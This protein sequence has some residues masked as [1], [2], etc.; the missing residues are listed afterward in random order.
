MMLKDFIIK[1]AEG[2]RELQNKDGSFP[3][4][5]NGPY[6]DPETPVRN[7]GHWLVIFAKCYKLTGDDKFKTKVYEV[8]EYLC[9]KDARPNGY[10]FY[11]RNKKNKD[12][13]NGLIGQAW[14]FEALAEAT[15]LLNAGKYALLAEEVFLRHPFNEEYGL[16]NRL[17]V[18]GRVLTIDGTFNHQLWFAA[19]SSLI[20]CPRNPE[21]MSRVKRF[22]DCLPRN[23]TILKNGLVYHHIERSLEEQITHN[24]TQ[25]DKVKRCLGGIIRALKSIKWIERILLR[26]RIKGEIYRSVGYHSF[27]L[28]AFAILKSQF[29]K[30]PFWNSISLRKAVAYM[31]TDEYR[32]KIDNNKYG[33]SY[34]PP[35]FEIPYSLYILGDINKKKLTEISQWWINEQ[36]RRCYNEKTGMMDRNTEDALTHT[37]RIYELC[38]LPIDVFREITIWEY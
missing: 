24:F 35:G 30:H 26:I 16:W 12:R 36:F 27:N 15:R 33:Y 38:R 7:S 6:F 22:M 34:N 14:T 11:H 3:A 37:A 19:S 18:D 10:S 20:E 13:C 9:S 1:T 28:Y 31:L 32:D 5:H 29:P 23:L 2:M 8:A 21:I 4:G 17:E 25:R